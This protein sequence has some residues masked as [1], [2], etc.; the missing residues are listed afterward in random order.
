M[1]KFIAVCL[2]TLM[3][4]FMASCNK[5]GIDGDPVYKPIDPV[6]VKNDDVK[7][8]N[9]TD[10]LGDKQENVTENTA[11]QENKTVTESETNKENN[12]VQ[13]SPP[14]AVSSTTPAKDN[15]NNKTETPVA[16]TPPATKEQEAV[17]KVTPQV[18][19]H[20]PTEMEKY[21]L[22][23]LN[24]YRSQNGLSPLSYDSDIYEASHTRAKEISTKWSH[25]RPDGRQ[26]ITAIS[27]LNFTAP[28][29]YGENLSRNFTSNTINTAMERLYNSPSHR[30]NML[31]PN[32]NKVCICI[33]PNG[34][35]TFSMVQTFR[36]G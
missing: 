35:N 13:T 22:Q 9:K 5:K 25:T 26:S 19:N 12:D 3:T 20:S 33:I 30:S 29:Y 8:E 34:E 28:A 24:N 18:S 6:V 14:P 16:S 10:I 17:V 27:D 32:Y 11:L 2:C 4:I 7:A 31:S 23:V 21:V 1:K 15:Q 36:K